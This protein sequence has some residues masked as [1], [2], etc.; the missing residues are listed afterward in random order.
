MQKMV[1]M[2]AMPTTMLAIVSGAHATRRELAQHH[3]SIDQ[4]FLS[5]KRMT[6]L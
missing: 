3:H 2:P 5:K 4:A 6:G 1:M